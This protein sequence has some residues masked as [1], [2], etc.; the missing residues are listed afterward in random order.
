MTPPEPPP[1]AETRV[2][3]LEA[4][5]RTSLEAKLVH[6]NYQPLYAN[7]A[8]ADLFLYEDVAEVLAQRSLLPLFDDD[9][10]ARPGPCWRDAVEA[11]GVLF[12]RR[13]YHRRTGAAVRVEMLSRRVQWE[14]EPAVALSLI[15]VSEE[16]RAGRAQAEA[17]A[18]A[19]AQALAHRAIR[20]LA[21][22]ALR[23][24]LIQARRALESIPPSL[25]SEAARAACDDMLVRLAD[26]DEL[27][28][29]PAPTLRLGDLYVRIE[30]AARRAAPELE[31][32]FAGP[33]DL[34]VRAAGARIARAIGR[35]VEAGE[36]AARRLVVR[37]GDGISVQLDAVGAQ[38]AADHFALARTLIEA[39]GGVLV[40]RAR[41]DAAWSAMAYLPAPRA[42]APPRRSPARDILVVED[43][44]GAQRMLIALL[45]ALGHRPHGVGDCQAALDLIAAQRFDVV[46][47]DLNLP[48]VDGLETA[49]RI[50]SLPLPWADLP[51]AAMTASEAPTLQAAVAEAGMDAF[52][53][54]PIEAARL[55]EQIALLTGGSPSA[56]SPS[57]RLIEAAEL[58]HVEQEDQPDKAENEGE[59]DQVYPPGETSLIAL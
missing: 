28:D 58:N 37:H 57:G 18:A 7:P 22:E 59:R 1:D 48:G 44:Q 21:L 23:P 43:N 46:L 8:F 6:R 5:L 36:G 20:S 11:P 38:R 3:R 40:M 30:A 12:G 16:E 34:I 41:Q 25:D 47:M 53:M 14:G 27:L 10:R 42:T 2:E 54:K 24:A 31:I 49:R 33:R 15:D 13:L 29:D 4:L 9:T 35:L 26:L 50:R 39:E 56:S 51:I 45:R 19:D 32:G 52:L 55:A 17:F